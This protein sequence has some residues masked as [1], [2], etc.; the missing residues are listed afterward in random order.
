MVREGEG[1]DMTEAEIRHA[2]HESS[3]WPF[4]TGAS[5]LLCALALLAYFEWEWTVAAVVLGGGALAAVAIGVAGWAREFFTS[6]TDEGVGVV[7]VAVFIISEVIIFGT[8]FA[9]FWLGRI[10]HADSWGEM[11]PEALDPSFALLL[12]VILWA[13][14]ASIFYAE[15]S[16]TEG[17][18]NGALSLLAVTFGLGL[19]FVVLHV[20]E[21]Q[22][23]MAGGFD[24]GANIYA[25]TFYAL[26]G[27]HTA[28]VIVGLASHLV[29]LG[30]IGRNLIAVERVTLF[31]GTSLYW[32]FVDIMWLLVAANVYLIGGTF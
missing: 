28:H 2:E 15:K 29:L 10:D 13:S 23:L 20:N 18:R 14:S 5:V 31:K 12:T 8:I 19:A 16:F 30:L 3:V 24:L 4:V 1:V 25:T 26:T 27:V 21:W 6:G 32:H 11:I 7:A 22:H 9:A 17:K